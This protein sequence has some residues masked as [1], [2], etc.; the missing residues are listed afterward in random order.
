MDI[1]N[2]QDNGSQDISIDSNSIDMGNSGSLEGSGQ[3]AVETPQKQDYNP[4]WW[5][6]DDRAKR[7]MWTSP[8][9]VVKSYYHL[10]KEF[11][12]KYKPAYS[13]YEKLNQTFNKL[14]IKPDELETHWQEYNTLKDPNHENNQFISKVNTYLQNPEY[15]QTLQNV[16]TDLNKRDLQRQFPGYNE[17]QIQ[18]QL[19]IRQELQE[20]K[21][22]DA[23]REAEIQRQEQAKLQ[24]EI[25]KEIEQN[26]KEIAD[27]AKEKGITITDEMV[28]DYFKTMEESNISP[29]YMK[30]LFMQMYQKEIFEN[31]GK[32]AS[33]NTIKNLNKNNKNVIPSA[34]TKNQNAAPTKDMSFSDRV[35][36]SV[37]KI[38]GGA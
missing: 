20:L 4:D 27:F 11:N 32:K 12:T 14:G 28:K 18:E 13:E 7:G 9:H 16:F 34:A 3:Q 24:I 22:R 8:E 1:N 5:K 35:M 2:L 6:L 25:Q 38:R 17:E 15:A 21:N 29:K 33:E 10:D 23:Q 19:L 30:G 36:S 31:I 26:I 37:N